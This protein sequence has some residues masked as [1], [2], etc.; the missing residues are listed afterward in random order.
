M[1]EQNSQP[2]K[3][4]TIGFQDPEFNEAPFAAGVANHLKTEHSELL[5]TG[6]DVTSLVPDLP[7]LYDEPFADYSVKFDLFWF[8]KSAKQ[9]VTV[10]LSG[11]A[12]DELF[13]GYNRYLLAPKLWKNLLGF[14]NLLEKYLAKL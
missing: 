9:A 1:Q 13:G 8:G 2:I 7:K 4:F 12:G 14:L 10:S 3:T 5:V 11:D 6:E